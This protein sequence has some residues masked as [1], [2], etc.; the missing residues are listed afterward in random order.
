MKNVRCLDTK[1]AETS[2][3][4]L[5]SRPK[6]ET[7]NNEQPASWLVGCLSSLCYSGRCDLQWGFL[8]FL[9]VSSTNIT[10][11]RP[12][13]L[14]AKLKYDQLLGKAQIFLN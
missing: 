3:S 7:V 6:F 9:T 2:R 1:Q 13:P 10:D 8:F 11:V 4:W 12:Y 14:G 5:K